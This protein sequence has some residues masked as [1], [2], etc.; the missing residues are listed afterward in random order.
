VPVVTFS[1]TLSVGLSSVRSTVL[2]AALRVS[3]ITWGRGEGL[4]SGLGCGILSRRTRSRT[5]AP[6]IVVFPTTPRLRLS[7]G[8]QMRPAL[9]FQP[10]RRKSRSWSV[11]PRVARRL[12]PWW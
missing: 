6:F 9:K 1:K 2:L 11:V 5:T 7:N 8:D 4:G 10:E 3:T 12:R